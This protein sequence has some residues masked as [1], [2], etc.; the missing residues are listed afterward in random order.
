M[1][2]GEDPYH[3]SWHGSQTHGGQT[4]PWRK[5]GRGT[6]EKEEG[7]PNHKGKSMPR[8]ETDRRKEVKLVWIV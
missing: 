6:L 3:L 7:N 2:G 1:G 4:A 8:K 5:E